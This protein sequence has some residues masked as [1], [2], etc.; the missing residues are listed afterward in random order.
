VCVLV[1]VC[2]CVCVCASLGVSCASARGCVQTF[3]R[4]A[5]YVLVCMPSFDFGLCVCVFVKVKELV[6]KK[7]GVWGEVWKRK[8][9]NLCLQSIAFLPQSLQIK[10][11][12]CRH[13]LT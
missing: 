10:H 9:N 7:K 3:F 4:C 13:F 11:G 5:L 8:R 6:W 2:V 12:L 1:C